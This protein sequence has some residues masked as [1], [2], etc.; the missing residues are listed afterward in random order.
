MFPMKE[1]GSLIQRGRPISDVI[2][3]SLESLNNVFRGTSDDQM[4]LDMFASVMWL[5]DNSGRPL[6]YGT[7]Y[8]PLLAMPVPRQIWPEKPALN[9]YWTEIDSPARPMYRA[10]MVASML[11]EAYA[12]FGLAGII[13]VPFTLMYC[14]GKFYLTAMRRRYLSVYRFMYVVVASC[15]ILIFRDGLF[16]AIVFPIVNMMPLVAIAVLSYFSF[17]R[18]QTWQSLSSERGAAQ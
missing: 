18:A 5:V 7:M 3:V 16:S 2:D 15:S 8:Y 9:W 17:R 11:G 12:N 14:L 13:I 4:F 10:G 1:V 6:F